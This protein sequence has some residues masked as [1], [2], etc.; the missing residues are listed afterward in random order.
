MEVADRQHRR[1]QW[2]LER[3]SRRNSLA[4]FL[5]N[6]TWTYS[7]ERV[8]IRPT[9]TNFVFPAR[10][11]TNPNPKV[12][13][14][15]NRLEALKRRQNDS[16]TDAVSE[17]PTLDNSTSLET[18][19]SELDP[20][21][22]LLAN[23]D[24]H[25]ELNEQQTAYSSEMN[26]IADTKSMNL[27]DSTGTSQEEREQAGEH[28]MYTVHEAS[29]L[30]ND[31][32][33]S[34]SERQPGPNE[35]EH[36]AATFTPPR[37]SQETPSISTRR[38]LQAMY[39]RMLEP[40]NPTIKKLFSDATTQES[41]DDDIISVEAMIHQ[42]VLFPLTVQ[43]HLVEK[44]VLIYFTEDLR[45]SD[46]LHLIRDFVLLGQGIVTNELIRRLYDPTQDMQLV[47]PSKAFAEALVAAQMVFVERLHFRLMFIGQHSWCS[48]YQLY[49]CR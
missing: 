47:P 16:M 2:R 36:R 37:F 3:V 21:E 27:K 20:S 5:Q 32:G 9:E 46:R 18:V 19:N 44:A 28:E 17:Q 48:R 22:Q 6:D 31:L 15:R 14:L 7:N 25:S 34:V 1:L 23:S 45:I 35:S 12:E 49:C 42:G 43:H 30:P 8:Q 11:S 39:S 24:V 4:S 33:A 38:N 41:N 26:E 10:T 40:P 13:M 29:Q